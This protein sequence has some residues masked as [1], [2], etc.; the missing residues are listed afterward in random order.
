ML[1]PFKPSTPNRT[2]GR[3]VSDQ[4]LINYMSSRLCRAYMA[5]SDRNTAIDFDWW[6]VRLDGELVSDIHG[7]RRPLHFS[8]RIWPWP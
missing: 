1:W 7:C 8:A 3:N 5:F 4:D 2:D 6:K